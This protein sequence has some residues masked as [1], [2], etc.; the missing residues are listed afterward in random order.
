M[1]G[2]VM[3]KSEDKQPDPLEGELGS[4]IKQLNDRTIWGHRE[5]ELRAQLVLLM[6]KL[7]YVHLVGH[8]NRYHVT[9]VGESCLY[10]VPENRR[11]T[12]KVF[13][14]RRIRLICIR[15][16]RYDRGLMAGPIDDRAV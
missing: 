3:F 13:R 1:E 7:G 10:D 14:G 5:Q 6:E 2:S 16:G 8:P 12:L 11:G 9:L 4:L 15:S